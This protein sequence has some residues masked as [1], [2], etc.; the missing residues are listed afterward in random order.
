MAADQHALEVMSAFQRYVKSR[1]LAEIEH[2]SLENL[3]H[4]D[5][6]LGDRDVNTPF[7]IALRNRIQNIK[8]NDEKN[9]QSLVQIVGYVVTFV[10]GVLATLLADWL[11]K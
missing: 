4:A 5:E 2:Y 11:T 1:D 10:A 6:S 9:Y 3:L 8:N 7:R